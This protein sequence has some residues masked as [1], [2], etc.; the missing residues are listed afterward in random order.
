MKLYLIE[1]G[2]VRGYDTYDSAVVIATGE[3]Q[4]RTIY[5]SKYGKVIEY[6][7]PITNKSPKYLYTR[8]GWTSNPEDVTAT[9]LGEADAKYTEPTVICASFNAG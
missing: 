5:P 8:D 1:Q 3:I 9:Y 4:A 6:M 7:L 2:A